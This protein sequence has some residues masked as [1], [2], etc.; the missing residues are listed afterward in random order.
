MPLDDHFFRRES[1]RLV[2]SLTRIFGVHNLSLAEDVA[3]EAFCRALEVWSLRGVPENPQAWLMAT[4]KN[5]AL[6]VLRRQ[7]T[8][9]GHAPEVERMLQ[10][11]QTVEPALDDLLLP[12]ALK[13][14]LLRMMF[15]CC[16]PRLTEGT[17][18][19]LVLQILCGF[20]VGETAAAFMSSHAAMEKRLGRAK[21]VLATSR[22]LFDIASSAQV[23]RRLPAVQRAL[24]LLFNEGYHG[25]SA[26]TSIRTDLCRE[27]MRLT[28]VLLGDPRCATPATHALGALMCLHA[29]R[30]PARID[31]VGDLVTLCDQDRTQWDQALVVD[32]LSL[33]EAAATGPDLS[34]YH[35]E[36]AIAAIHAN[37]STFEATDWAAIV[38]LYDML[39]RLQPSPIV[40]LNRAVAIALRS[41]P[42]C[43][44]AEI[45]RMR[46][47]DRLSSYPFY[48]AAL[49]ELERRSGNMQA[50]RT[51][52]RQALN[53]ARNSMERRFYARQLAVG[54]TAAAPFQGLEAMWDHAFDAFRARVE[55]DRAAG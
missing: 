41:G 39:M 9:A 52:F 6:D 47:L 54:D 29:A 16:D 36:A 50:A 28:A 48:F 34:A 10:S 30:L 5:R 3:Q 35:L 42:A 44:L 32:G 15:A 22:R 51:H 43:G 25:A 17:Q 13:D 45:R 27:A 8:A 26:E 7:R 12:G 1:G 53:L 18:V 4:A 40:A 24:Y 55:S 38:S 46:D 31:S 11:G 20:S 14:D 37:A 49:G 2:S 21:A 23:A 33:L 19:L